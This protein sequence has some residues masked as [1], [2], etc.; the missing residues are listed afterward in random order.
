MSK[1]ITLPDGQKMQADK[2]WQNL[3]HEQQQKIIGWMRLAFFAYYPDED[4]ILS[5][6]F[7]K[8]DR[9]RIWI[10]DD[11]VI[12]K[13]NK[14]KRRFK[15]QMD[16]RNLKAADSP[17]PLLKCSLCGTVK[18]QKKFPYKDINSHFEKAIQIWCP[19]N[20]CKKEHRRIVP[21]GCI[22]YTWYEYGEWSTIEPA[23]IEDMMAIQ[24]AKQLLE[25]GRELLANQGKDE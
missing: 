6:V 25:Q 13:Y 19:L 3:S 10:P 17:P 9:C 18:N 8:I 12:W 15:R 22:C 1:H 14:H 16:A 23:T 11:E 4:A 5:E 20:A 2:K 7:R 21:D 24:R